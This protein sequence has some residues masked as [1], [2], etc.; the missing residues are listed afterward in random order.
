MSRQPSNIESELSYTSS[1]CRVLWFMNYAGTVPVC[2]VQTTIWTTSR[3]RACGTSAAILRLIVFMADRRP[4][5]RRREFISPKILFR[6]SRMGLS[7]ECE[8]ECHG[9]TQVLTNAGAV[10]SV[11]AMFPAPAVAQGPAQTTKRV[12]I[13]QSYEKGHV[14]GEPQAEGILNALA[15]AGGQSVAT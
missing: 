7:S 14:C 2:G 5:L 8:E 6:C 9:S 1:E 11:A 15:A 4:I 13:V 12:Y 3:R 10:A